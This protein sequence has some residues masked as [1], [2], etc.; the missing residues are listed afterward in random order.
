MNHD[1]ITVNAPGQIKFMTLTNLEIKAIT[2]N[3]HIVELVLNS[4]FTLVT[5]FY[6]SENKKVIYVQLIFNTIDVAPFRCN[7]TMVCATD[8]SDILMDSESYHKDVAL[9]LGASAAC[10][11]GK[12]KAT[13]EP[14]IIS[15]CNQI[16]SLP[17]VF[18]SYLQKEYLKHV[19][20]S[21]TKSEWLNAGA[22]RSHL[23]VDGVSLCGRFAKE[24]IVKSKRLKKHCTKCESKQ[25]GG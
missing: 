19:D 4:D 25:H 8:I 3:K 21:Q 10:M 7:A 5:S 6:F 17:I 18:F 22:T 12:I 24:D 14:L 9:I 1:I 23:F 20:Q 13:L 2:P 15:M 16:I 11:W